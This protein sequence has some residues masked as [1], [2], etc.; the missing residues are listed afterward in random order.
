MK[1]NKGKVYLVGAG[2]GDAD[3]L[4]V[5]AVRLLREADAIVYDRL[6]SEEILQLANPG[7][8]LYF[9]GKGDGMHLFE[10]EE[11]NKLLENLA[12]SYRTIVR[13]KGGDPMVF[14]RGWE[15]LEYL[16]RKGIEVE[17]VP[18]VSSVNGVPSAIGLPLTIRG[19]SA[20]VMIVTGHEDPTK[21]NG[22][23]DWEAAARA[24][25][26]V[27]LMGVHYRQQIARTLIS[28]GRSPA[29]Y[30]AIIERGCTPEQRVT[31]TT[32]GELAG[33]SVYVLPP[34]VMVFGEVVRKYAKLAPFISKDI[35]QAINGH[36]P[37]LS[38]SS[39]NVAS[40][41]THTGECQQ[42]PTHSEIRFQE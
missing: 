9:V 10:Q 2:P 40:S 30:V 1:N 13:L 33:G 37:L 3:L 34:A 31:L 39:V 12:K 35:R 21:K 20:S 4:T 32:L 24:G 8:K 22:F 7:A 26:L 27:V 16:T 15:E 14:G 19:V 18:G 5:R 41:L 11:I 23:V 6:V 25:T 36:R 28:Y 38:P 29:E 42:I 17:V